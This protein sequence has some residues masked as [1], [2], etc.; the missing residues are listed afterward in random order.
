ML[1]TRWC[2][3]KRTFAL[4]GKQTATIC[5]TPLNGEQKFNYAR[6]EKCIASLERT[7]ANEW[8]VYVTLGNN[9]CSIK[10]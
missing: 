3:E 1:E 7:T 9:K 10:W 8:D 2:A 6:D 4:S 5:Q